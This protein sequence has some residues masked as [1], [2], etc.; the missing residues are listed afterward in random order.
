MAKGAKTCENCGLKGWHAKATRAYI[1]NFSGEKTHVC[2]PCYT[3][4]MATIDALKDIKEF[5]SFGGVT[6]DPAQDQER[7]GEQMCRV[8][9]ACLDGG[10]HTLADLSQKTGDPESS[11]S[12]RLRDVRKKW[13][14]D[15]MESKRLKEGK[16]T[17]IY[18]VHVRVA[19]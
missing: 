13:G 18:R 3:E 15:A 9:E 19:A 11:V 6:Y 17:W 7:L 10:W 2:E 12:A 8:L 14:K 5:E 4:A 16:G 1:S